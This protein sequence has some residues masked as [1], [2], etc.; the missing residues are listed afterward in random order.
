MTV[1]ELINKLGEFHLDMLVVVDGY[2]GGLDDP[3]YPELCVIH[4]NQNSEWYYGKHEQCEQGETC[5]YCK[6]ETAHKVDAVMIK[7]GG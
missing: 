6:S 2:E 4:L 1:L 3:Q 7:R 5:T